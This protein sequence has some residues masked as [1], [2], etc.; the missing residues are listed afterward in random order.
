MC[1]S[2][3]K[4]LRGQADEWHRTRDIPRRQLLV[5]I[6]VATWHYSTRYYKQSSLGG[7]PI[8][9]A[10]DQHELLNWF[11]RFPDGMQFSNIRKCTLDIVRF[12]ISTA[13]RVSIY[14]LTVPY[15]YKRCSTAGAIALSLHE[16][17]YQFLRKLKTI[18]HPFSTNIIYA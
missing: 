13:Q 12:L 15:H 5:D 11:N 16:N 18:S 9:P 3:Y 1:F 8:Y 2:G 14:L 4:P 10:P 7:V 17:V 6:N